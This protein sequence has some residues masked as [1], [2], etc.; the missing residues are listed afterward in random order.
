MVSGSAEPWR[1]AYLGIPLSVALVA[2]SPSQKLP[3]WLTFARTGFSW[4]QEPTITPLNL[5]L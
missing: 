5:V 4:N 1:C 3:L 2:R